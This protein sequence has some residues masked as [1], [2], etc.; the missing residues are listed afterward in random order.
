MIF[1]HKIVVYKLIW[2]L[3]YN[4]IILGLLK[5]NAL[6]QKKVGHRLV[7]QRENLGQ[8]DQFKEITKNYSQIYQPNR[9]TFLETMSWFFD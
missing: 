7:S 2:V 6:T 4:L 8:Y 1:L 9:L 5:N 3:P